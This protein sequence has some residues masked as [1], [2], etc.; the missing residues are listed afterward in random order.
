[1]K[2]NKRKAFLTLLTVWIGVA[3]LYQSV[4]IFSRTATAEV[5]AA[6]P[7]RRSGGI[8]G[9]GYRP[10]MM[11]ATYTVGADTYQGSYFRDEGNVASGHF[12]VRY[13]SFAPD[14]SRKESFAGNWGYTIIFLLIASLITAILF[15]RKDIIAD[16]AVFIIQA[17]RPFVRLINNSIADYDEHTIGTGKYDAAE[18]ALRKRIE[19]EPD[20][21]QRQE[22]ATP[23]YKLN[24]NAI[25]IFVGYL[26]PFYWFFQLLLTERS[27]GV[28]TILLGAFL[29]FVPL[30]VQ[31]TGNPIFKAKIPNEG[32]LSFSADGVQ[33][34][35]EFYAVGDIE[36]AAVY[37]EAFKGFKY[38]EQGSMGHIRSVSAGDNNQIS[39]RYKGE[40]TDLTFI[41]G[42]FGDYWSFKNLVGQWPTSGVH[43]VLKKVF[44]DEFVIQ[45][46][47]KYGIPA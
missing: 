38:D 14:V 3:L 20:I 9:R 24:P 1:M 29:V 40:V 19:T 8:F 21:F 15:L 5:Y 39:F 13:L 10:S 27:V 41:L 17:K 32:S 16:H 4:W 42:S 36:V 7:V 2:L 33:Y 18:Q 25:A 37:L 34:K 31:N 35:D 26:F 44:E 46:V 47:V 45:E 6:D 28:G 43:V 23:V 30:F 11:Y 22:V 12:T